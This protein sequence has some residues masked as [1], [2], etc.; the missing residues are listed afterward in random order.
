MQAFSITLHK[1]FTKG[2]FQA[3]SYSRHGDSRVGP[4][5]L[6]PRISWINKKHFCL[7]QSKGAVKDEVN[8]VG[9]MASPIQLGKITNIGNNVLFLPSDFPATRATFRLSLPH[10]AWSSVSSFVRL[11]CLYLNRHNCVNDR[12]LIYTK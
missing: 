11:F 10:L 12:Q 6:S 7:V 8:W 3:R 9:A 4:V 1:V 2:H 5:W